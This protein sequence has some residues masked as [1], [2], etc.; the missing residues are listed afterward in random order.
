M[1]DAKS[2]RGI[3]S[4]SGEQKWEARQETK[5]VLHSEKNVWRIPAQVTEQGVE[6]TSRHSIFIPSVN[7]MKDQLNVRDFRLLPQNEWSH[8]NP[9]IQRRSNI[10]YNTSRKTKRRIAIR[11]SKY[12]SETGFSQFRF[13]FLC[14]IQRTFI[15]TH[16]CMCVC[17]L[18][19]SAIF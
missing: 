13:Y 4:V 1:D 15:D 8:F 11:L 16:F 10:C 12:L 2:H 6:R 17:C 5:A 7:R 19:Q 3:I 18:A 9:V 14:S